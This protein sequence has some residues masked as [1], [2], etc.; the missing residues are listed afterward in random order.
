MIIE[1]QG[2]GFGA[3]S[4]HSG[5][6]ILLESIRVTELT[7]HI[8]G[9]PD[10]ACIDLQALMATFQRVLP[11][12]VPGENWSPMRCIFRLADHAGESDS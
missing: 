7:N 12:H 11:D 1:E 10:D 2:W 4:N 9:S 6:I 5:R 3:W 8:S